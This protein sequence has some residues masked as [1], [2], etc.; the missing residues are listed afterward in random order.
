MGLILV[1]CPRA[2]SRPFTLPS[3]ILPLRS[4]S[5]TSHSAQHV[6]SCFRAPDPIKDVSFTIQY[7]ARGFNGYCFRAP[8]PFKSVL[9][10]GQCEACGFKG[11]TVTACSMSLCML[12]SAVCWASSAQA[13]GAVEHSVPG[14]ISHRWPDQ[15][16][17]PCAYAT[18][19]LRIT[20]SL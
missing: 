19:D 7:E 11:S 9:L 3:H 2:H 4:T 20:G 16:K 13:R 18:A 1:A 12:A 14:V 10:I 5:C 15:S 6:L 8:D 17:P